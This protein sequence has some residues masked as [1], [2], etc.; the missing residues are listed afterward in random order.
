MYFTIM[1]T[2][3]EEEN[4]RLKKQ[5][6]KTKDSLSEEKKKKSTLQKQRRNSL[7][8]A[9]S[10]EKNLSNYREENFALKAQVLETTRKNF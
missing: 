1:R 8:V 5:Y 9:E 3:V 6:K 7:F 10:L 2:Q 4:Y